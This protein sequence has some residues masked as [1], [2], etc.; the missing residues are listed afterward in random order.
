MISYDHFFPSE[1]II[2]LLLLPFEFLIHSADPQSR[3]VGIIVFAHVSVRTSVPT[4]QNI[5]KQTSRELMGL[6]VRLAEWIID[7][8]C[9]VSFLVRHRRMETTEAEGK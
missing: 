8:S 7:D 2:S 5:V 1:I 3:P 4:F 6:C 9:L